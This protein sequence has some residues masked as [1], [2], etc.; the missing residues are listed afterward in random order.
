MRARLR[1][2]NCAR[3]C[4]VDEVEPLATHAALECF[5]SHTGV[6]FASRTLCGGY[7]ACEEVGTER[8][9]REDLAVCEL[10]VRRCDAG[11]GSRC[12]KS[13]HELGETR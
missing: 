4:D 5:S 12:G 2:F 6:S 11:G 13:L 8:P 1:A 3:L 9:S 7:E 10:V